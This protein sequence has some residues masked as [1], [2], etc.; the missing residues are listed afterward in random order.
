MTLR[1]MTPAD[2]PGAVALQRACFPPPFPADLLW[3]EAHLQAHL[4]RFPQ[5]Q[6]VALAGEQVIGSASALLISER[7][8]EAHAD[9]ETTTG[10]HYFEAHD[11]RGTTLFGADISVDP[12]WRGQGVGRALYQ[13]RFDLVRN[14]GVVRFGTAC[15]IPDWLEWSVAHRE[16]SKQA[17][18]LAVVKGETRDRTLT[19]LL[20]MGLRYRGIVE[21]HMDDD[22][23]GDAAAILEWTP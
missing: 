7:N 23:S 10:G 14:L 12:A 16:S 21:G 9:W 19:P 20:R 11:P 1:A 17:Y 2:L 13:A 4:D 6:F 18:A 5:G 15:R 22:E 3:S 8:W